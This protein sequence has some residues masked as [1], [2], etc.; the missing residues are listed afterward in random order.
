MIVAKIGVTF[1][2]D[3]G[4]KIKNQSISFQGQRILA[5]LWQP[6]LIYKVTELT[7]SFIVSKFFLSQGKLGE[8]WKYVLRLESPRLIV[9][10]PKI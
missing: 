6:E 10:Y 5:E 9:D 1:V 2:S 4:M 3:Q 8:V 7:T